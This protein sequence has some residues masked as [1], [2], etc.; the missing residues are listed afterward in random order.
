[1]LTRNEEISAYN[2]QKFSAK[3]KICIH[4]I[5]GFSLPLLF[6]D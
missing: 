6:N 2:F 5:T 3:I 1:M 4:H